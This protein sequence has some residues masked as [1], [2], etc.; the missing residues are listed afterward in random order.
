MIFRMADQY[1]IPKDANVFPP[2]WK[3]D[4]FRTT[5]NNNN[6]TDLSQV[7]YASSPPPHDGFR[8][9]QHAAPAYVQQEQQQPPPPPPFP[10]P[11]VTAGVAPLPSDAPPPPQ[12]QPNGSPYPYCYYP[13]QQLFVN[14][15]SPSPSYGFPVQQA[16]ERRPARKRR[17]PP[18]SYACL[19]AQAILTSPELR[20]TLREI[21]DW[22]QT[23]Y[24]SLYESNET[25]WQVNKNW[26]R[27][28]EGKGI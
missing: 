13:Q 11:P 22:I 21:Y 8:V 17:R 3:I 9:R 18:Y 25:G 24:P 1:A 10:S 16:N 26:P 7:Y 23:R 4:Q 28:M 27:W 6:N 12:P 2:N 14:S 19:I 15:P 5:N 20:L